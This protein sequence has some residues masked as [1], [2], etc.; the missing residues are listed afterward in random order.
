MEKPDMHKMSPK[1]T[2][3]EVLR[4][5]YALQGVTPKI[6]EKCMEA[7]VMAK[8]MDAKLRG[9]KADWSKDFFEPNPNYPGEHLK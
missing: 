1:R 8:K 5:I 2:I 6:Q 3:C 4:E 9:Y 7:V